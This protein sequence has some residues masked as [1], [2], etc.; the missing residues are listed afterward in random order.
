MRPLPYDLAFAD[1]AFEQTHFPAIREQ[2]ETYGTDTADPAQL[3]QLRGAADVLRTILSDGDASAVASFGPLL[4]QGYHYWRFGKNVISLDAPVLRPLLGDELQI[5]AWQM[6]P[7]HGAGYLQL[8][9]NLV[10]AKI[11][12]DSTPEA[13]DG[14]FWT[15]VGTGD[16]LVP[17][18]ARL[19][20]L[21]IL[22][23]VANRPGFSV[24]EVSTPMGSDPQGHWGDVKVRENEQLDFANVLPGGELQSLHAIETIGEAL[25]LASRVFWHLSQH[26]NG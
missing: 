22:G 7:P 18:F 19:D 20:L 1:P 9:R 10:W 5:G 3:L 11:A 6:V 23:L 16:P 8:P 4:F 13:I 17:P 26:P 25:K 21:L 14:L 12:E 24:V 2:A 15:M